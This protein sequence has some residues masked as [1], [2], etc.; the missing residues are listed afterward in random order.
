MCDLT[1]TLIFRLQ[2]KGSVN[3]MLQTIDVFIVF[4]SLWMQVQQM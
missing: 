2:E 3:S 4:F 1:I